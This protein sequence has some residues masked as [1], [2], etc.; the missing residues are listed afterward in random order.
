MISTKKISN[1]T[2]ELQDVDR[3]GSC[4]LHSINLANN[5]SFSSNGAISLRK[6]A[7]QYIR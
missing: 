4:L 6:A 7:A 3:D 2:F 1:I 5:G